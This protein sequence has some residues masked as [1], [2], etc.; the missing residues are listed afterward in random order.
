MGEGRGGVYPIPPPPGPLPLDT[1]FTTFNIKF[2]FIILD[3]EKQFRP[4]TELS[5]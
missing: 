3:P 1:V 2:K 4:F 5:L